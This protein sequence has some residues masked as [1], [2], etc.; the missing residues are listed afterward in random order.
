MLKRSVSGLEDIMVVEAFVNFT[1]QSRKYLRKRNICRSKTLW[2][3]SVSTANAAF[4]CKRGNVFPP[5]TVP[6]LFV[7][8]SYHDYPTGH[9]KELLDCAI[10]ST[11]I[12]AMRYGAC[13]AIYSVY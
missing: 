5:A 12:R 6:V 1:F 4:V 10:P 3:R 11:H 8:V 9:R 13:N 7:L 2:K